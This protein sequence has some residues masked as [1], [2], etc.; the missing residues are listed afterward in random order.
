MSAKPLTKDEVDELEAEGMGDLVVKL[1]GK[2]YNSED[3]HSCSGCDKHVLTEGELEDGECED[4]A[5][6]SLE[7]DEDLEELKAD[8]RAGRL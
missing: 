7:A 2:L 8:W 5:A 3:L 4:C 6:D 1:G